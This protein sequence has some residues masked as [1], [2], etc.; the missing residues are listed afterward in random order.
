MH[1]W[2]R[3]HTEKV[4]S[5][6]TSS[7]FLGGGGKEPFLPLPVAHLEVLKSIVRNL[8]AG[9]FWEDLLYSNLNYKGRL[10]VRK[11]REMRVDDWK[12]TKQDWHLHTMEAGD[13]KFQLHPNCI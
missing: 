7:F 13:R 10:V 12:N 2:Q 6:L 9:T 11:E 1:E 3:A 5:S 4:A 8:H